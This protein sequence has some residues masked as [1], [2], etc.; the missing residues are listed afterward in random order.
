VSA[1]R[2]EIL[3]MLSSARLPLSVADLAQDLSVSP[4]ASGGKRRTV[5]V[6]QVQKWIEQLKRECAILPVGD[7]WILRRVVEVEEK[8]LQ[9]F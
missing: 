4:L 5:L 3:E 8:Q 1:L 7:G 9:L 6:D 2:T